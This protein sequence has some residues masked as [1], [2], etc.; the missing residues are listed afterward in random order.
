MP[1]RKKGRANNRA[2]R[3]VG[4]RS[5]PTL[6][7]LAT[8]TNS[9]GAA[10]ADAP[11]DGWLQM[12]L[13]A[14]L[15]D[16]A[17]LGSGSG[18]G[19]VD[20][21]VARDRRERPVIWASHL[22]G[23]LRDAAR[24][25]CGEKIAS[26]FFGRAGGWQQRAVFTS[27]YTGSAP[28]TRIW[29]S[30]ARNAFDN[31]APRDDALRAI[32]HVRRGTCFEGRV[33]IAASD[34][35]LLRRLVQ[36]VDALGS[37]RAAG[38][39][40]VR[41]A[42][43]EATSACLAAGSAS[44]RLLLL[45]RNLDP[46]CITATATPDNLIPGMAFIPGRA[47]LG[48]LANWRIA[49]GDRDAA[50]ILVNGRLSV[51]DAL[52]VP[53]APTRLSAAEVLPAPLSLQSKKPLGAVGAVPWWVGAPAPVKRLDSRNLEEQE[54]QL[55]R[56]E[57]D[58]FVYR[59]GP[60]EPWI[61]F[62][63]QMRVRLR[64]GRPD[65]NQPDPSL[66]AVEQIAEDTL[67]LCEIRGELSDM[68][69][70]ATG[71]STV[72]KGRHWLRIGRAG[73]PVEVAG[74]EWT[75]A[76]SPTMPSSRAVVTLTSDLLIRD[77]ELRWCTN[78]DADRLGRLPGWPADI[79]VSSFVQDVVAVHGFNGTSRLWRIPS[80]GIRRG[81]VFDVEGDGVPELARRVA[82]GRWLGERT[83]QGFGRFRLDDTLPGTDV[84]A[85]GAATSVTPHVDE[86][87]EAIARMTRQW[88]EQHRSLAKV[89]GS[90]ERRPSLSQWMD[91][92]SELERGDGNALASR[93]N[94]T[95]AGGKSWNDPAAKKIVEH[96]AAIQ[97]SQA[98]A[99]YARHFIRWLRAE[100]RRDAK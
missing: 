93:R 2:A 83:H 88:L 38:A 95:T 48:A 61:A 43:A 26:D 9:A 15:L 99:A 40:R 84:G 79:R 18:G 98:R 45:L 36:E 81:T 49:D 58:L 23:V 10:P 70:V 76:A 35:P 75:A 16:D 52:P 53:R 37:G 94:P 41:L 74:L 46:L 85:T 42:L 91:L 1:K 3:P 24:R 87:E 21:L 29:R 60:G 72:L 71:L 14:E 27:L 55:K 20:A 6:D 44:G 4:G 25:I 97:D 19:G 86:P 90:A 65:P 34:L 80:Y 66:F 67:F 11:S 39:G 17:H 57:D 56:P 59:D 8:A 33:Q 32:E 13:S 69:R 31:R 77:E 89:G 22:E 68:D 100:M 96:L 28:Q 82:E 51:S 50:N 78:L 63:P 54:L 30:A 12:K 92:V 5:S 73:A 62:R 47:L 7:T 64:N